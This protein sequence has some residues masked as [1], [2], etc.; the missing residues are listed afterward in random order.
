MNPDQNQN[1]SPDQTPHP[2]PEPLPPIQ[3]AV[4]PVALDSF[5]V[6]DYAH[7]AAVE[8]K[9]RYHPKRFILWLSIFV[10]VCIL[11]VAT[12][13]AFALLPSPGSKTS[14]TTPKST[15]PVSNNKPVTAELAIKHVKEYFKGVE[16]AKTPLFRPVQA[17]TMAYFTVVPDTAPLV[18]VAGNVTPDKASAQL[19]AI[20]HS[21]I[22]DKFAETVV[23]DGTNGANYQVYFTNSNTTCE[24]DQLNTKDVTANVWIEAKCLDMATYTSY[25]VAQQPLASLYTPLSATSVQY[26]FVGK[27]ATVA[28]STAGYKYTQLQVSIVIDNQMTSSGQFALYYQTPDGLWHYFTNQDNDV[29]IDCAQYSTKDLQ[30]TYAGTACRDLRKG[31]MSTVP[32]PRRGNY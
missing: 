23:S 16:Q 11:A 12:M 4:T 5:E 21:L 25:A 15:Q 26:G 2:S 27:P 14:Q 3:P 31:T 9:H 18:S 7:P 30:S 24:L 1:P 10:A 22:G 8:P 32:A 13:L 20:I 6:R 28:G 29:A 17:P 19:G